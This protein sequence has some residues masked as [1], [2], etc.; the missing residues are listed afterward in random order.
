VHLISRFFLLNLTK[1]ATTV[2]WHL[3]TKI[4]LSLSKR[5]ETLLPWTLPLSNL[6]L[7]QFIEPWFIEPTVNRTI[8]R[9][10]T[11]LTVDCL[12]RRHYFG[13][14]SHSAAA[15]V[16]FYFKLFQEQSP[17]CLYRP[18]LSNLGFHSPPGVLFLLKVWGWRFNCVG[19][20][21]CAID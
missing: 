6:V 4:F 5:A 20:I 15:I 10:R 3:S 8:Y 16:T 11:Y 1:E 19:M 17:F 7:R 2:L 12:R 18:R 13:V 14:E 9:M 21:L